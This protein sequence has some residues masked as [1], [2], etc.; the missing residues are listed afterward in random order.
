MLSLPP[1][2]FTPSPS[3]IFLHFFL[4]PDSPHQGWKRINLSCRTATFPNQAPTP[5]MLAGYA[6]GVHVNVCD[7]AG[8]MYFLWPN[9]WKSFHH[10][11]IFFPFT[12]NISAPSGNGGWLGWFAGIIRARF[13]WE[14][15]SFLPRPGGWVRVRGRVRVLVGDKIMT[16]H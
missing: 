9:S 8:R 2:T 5:I 13:V 7:R 14:K 1:S 16:S 12:L 15:P 6:L 4:V 11:M 3:L 10:G